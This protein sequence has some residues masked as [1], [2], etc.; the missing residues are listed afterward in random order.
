MDRL[1]A[2]LDAKFAYNLTIRLQQA[3]LA[4]TCYGFGAPL[5]L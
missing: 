5:D 3:Q 4:G 1:R 2:V